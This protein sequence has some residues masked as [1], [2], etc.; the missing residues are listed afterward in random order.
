MIEHGLLQL[1]AQDSGV[2]ALVGAKVY[3]ILAP[4]GAVVPY[5]VLSRVVTKNFYDMTGAT[6]LQEGL[7]QIDCYATDFYASRAISKAVRDLL[8][9]YRGTLPEMDNTRLQAAFIDKD[10][11]LPYQEGSKGFVYRAMLHVRVEFEQP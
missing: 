7:F 10:W 5:V 1:V 6:G 2:S 11:D 4:K 9:S 8:K 3:W